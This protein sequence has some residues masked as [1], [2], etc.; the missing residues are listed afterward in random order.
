MLDSLYIFI[1]DIQATTSQH[2]DLQSLKAYIIRSRPHTKDEVVHSVQ[3]YGPIRHE[4]VMI[5]GIAMKGK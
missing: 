1:A 3:K 5:D 2:V 4:L